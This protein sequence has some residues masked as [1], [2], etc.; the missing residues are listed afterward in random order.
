MGQSGSALLPGQ[1]R[2]KGSRTRARRITLRRPGDLLGDDPLSGLQQGLPVTHLRLHARAR[3]RGAAGR[4][5]LL[6]FE[7]VQAGRRATKEPAA[8]E[9][10]APVP[11][12]L[13]PQGVLG[14]QKPQPAQ[15]PKQTEKK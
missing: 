14:P 9:A 13:I 11:A 1:H 8:T 7:E 5:Q 6:Q 15:N 4:G 12:P 10:A 2:D 3:E